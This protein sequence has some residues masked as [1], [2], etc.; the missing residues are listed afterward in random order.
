[1]TKDSRGILLS[2]VIQAIKETQVEKIFFMSFIFIALWKTFYRCSFE[3]D[4]TFHPHATHHMLRKRAA[5]TTEFKCLWYLSSSPGCLVLNGYCSF[6]IVSI[7]LQIIFG[8]MCQRAH[9]T[10]ANGVDGSLVGKINNFGSLNLLVN[11]LRSLSFLIVLLC[12][13]TWRVGIF[14]TNV[15]KE[16]FFFV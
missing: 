7:N 8:G 6:N 4:G 3:K 15:S 11:K 5:K 1:M 2:L 9:K 16:G 12:F 14:F 10:T 13:I